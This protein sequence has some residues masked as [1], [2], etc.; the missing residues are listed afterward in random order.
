[1][2]KDE[3]QARDYFQKN[4]PLSLVEHAEATGV[5][6]GA[7]YFEKMNFI[8]GFLLKKIS[9]KTVSFEDIR[10]ERIRDF[11]RQFEG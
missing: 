9:G 7:L 11:V 10:E 5:L 2:T 3:E 4:F 1:M 8:E 6:G